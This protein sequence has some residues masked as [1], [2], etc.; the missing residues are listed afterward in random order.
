MALV[1]VASIWGRARLSLGLADDPLATSVNVS[2]AGY[3]LLMLSVVARAIR[4][5][6][7]GRSTPR[8]PLRRVT[9][10]PRYADALLAR[11]RK[12]PEVGKEMDLTTDVRA[13][14]VAV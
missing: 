5:R 9:S 6:P 10:R 11:Q 13:A 7:E 3:P 1:I 14:G 12:Y 4:Y 2:R 8:H